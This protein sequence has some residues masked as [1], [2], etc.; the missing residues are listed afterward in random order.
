MTAVISGPLPILGA[1]AVIVGLLLVDLLLFA[2]GREPTFREG[3]AWSVGW[4]VLSLAVAPLIAVL[5]DSAAAVDYTTVYLIE[6]TLSLDNLFVF[7]LLFAYFGI[8]SSERPRLLF[9]GIALALVL[10]G[11]AILGGTALIE[12]FHI[13]IYILGVTLLFL[14]YRMFKGV[15][16]DQDPEQTLA[17]RMA[18]KLRPSASPLALCLVSIVVADIAFAIDSIPAAFAIT[19]DAFA[20]WMANAFALLGLRALFVLVEG[21]IRRFRFLDETIAVVLAIVAVKLLIEDLVHI[22]PVVSLGIVV[23]AFAIGM[24]AS[25]IADRR[26]PDAEAKRA[27]RAA[28]TA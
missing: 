13:V 15:G 16:H 24:I 25:T 17:V 2:R 12:R 26:D 27:E 3:V 19:T 1:A 8:G 14:A 21:L 18:R 20:I 7:L 10:R 23:V 5:D 28:R 6:R 4:L 9:W 22:G 11:A